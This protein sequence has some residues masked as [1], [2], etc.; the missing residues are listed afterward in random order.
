MR[1]GGMFGSGVY[2]WFVVSMTVASAT[3]AETAPQVRPVPL[4][5]VLAEQSGDCYFGVYVPTRFGGA[6]TITSTAGS[7][8]E[9]DGPDSKPRQ[10]GEEIGFNQHGWYRFRVSGAEGPYSVE[11]KFV[12]V[13]QSKRK[14]WNYYY[15]PTKPDVIHE[16]WAGGNA[17]VDTVQVR[18]DD[19]FVATPGGYIAPGQDIVHPG[20]NG[21][22]ETAP[23]Q[24][25]DLTWFP[26]QY[27]DLTFR[28]GDGTLYQTPSPMLK[29]DQIF[30]SS[31]RA[32]EAA[33]IQNR[34][35]QRWPGHCLGGAVASIVLNEPE[36]AVPGMTK[37]ELKALW[38]ELGENHFNHKIGDYA[39]E[40]PAGPP[41]PGADECDASVA[42]FHNM[43]EQHI[44]GRRE[45]LL[46]NLR[47]FP[48]RGSRNEVWNHGVGR[49][50]AEF[51]AI[52]GKGPRSLSLKVAIEGNSGSSLNGKD[53]QPR[54]IQYEYT[55][56]YG[57]DGN[58]DLSNT[59]ACDWIS[60]GGEAL[61]A[62]L[63]LLQVVQSRWQGHNPYVT[64]ANV[65]ALDLANGGKASIVASAPQTF[66]PVTQYE[67]GYG[68]WGG[69]AR[70]PYGQPWNGYPPSMVN[71]NNGAGNYGGYGGNRGFF[72]GYFGR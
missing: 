6:L 71:M 10:N 21:L 35:I 3:G 8:S 42:R 7:V 37:D 69:Y 72:G 22:L 49:Y 27:D 12:Q 45:A 11:T 50:T 53:D 2:L 63:N 23:A 51:H 19:E 62:P 16:P 41:R 9:I 54:I 61:Y 1:F 14:P 48:P 20:P 25:D 5:G 26:N 33:N 36:P 60:V 68:Q 66:R 30:R 39:N 67:G 44:R 56:R 28:G 65:R 29:Y 18:G 64:E 46:A 32:W 13:G 47:A 38:V 43:L 59:Y 34:E 58:V 31:A 70:S 24:G 57:L 15:W 17:R 4:G 40:I 52:P 55:L